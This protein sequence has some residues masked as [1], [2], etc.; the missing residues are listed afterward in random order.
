MLIYPCT[1][2]HNAG[3][4]IGTTRDVSQAKEMWQPEQCCRG[5]K[6]LS[7]NI[8]GKNLRDRSVEKII[9]HCQV[10]I[11]SASFLKKA[12]VRSTANGAAEKEACFC[13]ILL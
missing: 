7:L 1:A 11:V 5:I 6:N 3:E 4:D 12:F 10:C 13:K 8:N 2:S 9:C